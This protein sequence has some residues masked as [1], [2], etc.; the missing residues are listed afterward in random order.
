MERRKFLTSSCKFCMGAALAAAFSELTGCGTPYQVMKTPIL[1]NKVEVPL[2][3]FAQSNTVFVR[4]E[5]WYYDIAVEKKAD[6]TYSA[7]LLQCTHQE[8]QLNVSGDGYTCSLHGSKFDKNGKVR[9]GPA[10]RS[11]EHYKTTTDSNNLFIEV[12]KTP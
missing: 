7:L 8:N 5:G 10:E 2:T 11:L 1:N 12:P 9:K 4:P 6:N 3:S